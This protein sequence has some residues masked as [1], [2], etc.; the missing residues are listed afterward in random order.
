MNRPVVPREALVNLHADLSRK[1]M[2]LLTIPAASDRSSPRRRRL[3]PFQGSAH[4]PKRDKEDWVFLFVFEPRFLVPLAPEG[5]VDRAGLIL[6]RKALDSLQPFG[7]LP[8]GFSERPL[9]EDRPLPR[10]GWKSSGS[11]EDLLLPGIPL[12]AENGQPAAEIAEHRPVEAFVA[13]PE[14][15]RVE[16]SG[17]PGAQIRQHLSSVM[18]Y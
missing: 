17:Q 13:P 4:A 10:R 16:R 2:R 1:S 12:S 8:L 6:H 5:A 15:S 18:Q 7:R 14:R 3:S 11:L 9:G